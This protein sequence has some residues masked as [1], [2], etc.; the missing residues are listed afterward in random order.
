MMDEHDWILIETGYEHYW[1]V[2]VKPDGSIV[3]FD[4]T[5]SET[6]NQD[7]FLWC[8]LCGASEKLDGVEVEFE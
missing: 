3:A 1:S 2:E 5:Q 4:E 6:G 7:D 8:R